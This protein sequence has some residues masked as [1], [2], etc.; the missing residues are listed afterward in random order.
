MRRIVIGQTANDGT[1]DPLRTA[2]QIV[3]AGFYFGVRCSPF[4][5]RALE[6][7]IIRCVVGPGYILDPTT[8]LV[9]VENG[10]AFT[11]DIIS[12][13]AV[14]TNVSSLSGLATAQVVAGDGLQTNCTIS[15]IGGNSITLNKIA[16][17]TLSGA[18]FTASQLSVAF[19]AAAS[20]KTR[21][22]RSV[23]DA[24]T[25]DLSVVTGVETTGTPAVPALPAG[26]L[27]AGQWLISDSMTVLN[28]DDLISDDRTIPFLGVNV[29]Y[30]STSVTGETGG[31]IDTGLSAVS[32]VVASLAS[33]ASI[34]GNVVTATAAGGAGHITVKVW[35]PTSSGDCTPIL[36]TVAKTVRWV[37]I[38]TP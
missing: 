11:A 3:N 32:N 34:N 10:G 16:T 14:L 23:I 29:I 19:S 9:I 6:T 1:G 21:I 33:D 27:P 7:P 12:G 36:A 35:K 2:A 13:S 20:G 15:S 26:K 5:P 24:V 28:D 22:D 37:A 25:G 17:K 8:G 30:G 31:D 4:A 18:Q 38:G